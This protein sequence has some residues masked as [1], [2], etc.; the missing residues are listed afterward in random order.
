MPDPFIQERALLT[1]ADIIHSFSFEE[2]EKLMEV[3][4][5]FFKEIPISARLAFKYGNTD[6][7]VYLSLCAAMDK[8]TTKITISDHAL[9]NESAKALTEPLENMPLYINGTWL[10]DMIANWRLS[11][12]K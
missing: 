10:T 2:I 8:K 11:I 1:M 3:I 4:D 5:H 9:S 6:S 12:S 7:P